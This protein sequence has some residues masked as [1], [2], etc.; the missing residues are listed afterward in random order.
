M[1]EFLKGYIKP[2][3][4]ILA[5]IIAFLLLLEVLSLTYFSKARASDYNN[6]YSETM[7]FYN[8][9]EN[10]LQIIGIGNSD[11]Y[12]GFAPPVIWHEYGYT[13]TAIGAPRQSPSECYDLLREVMDSQS[14]DVVFIECDMLYDNNAQ[15]NYITSK[16]NSLDVMFDYL[17]Q[18][19]VEEG[20][21]NVL[22]IF[23]FHDRWKN[24]K[25]SS[26]VNKNHGYKF[27]DTII[28]VEMSEGYMDET[29]E[30]E[31]IP[32]VHQ[33]S[34]KAII[35]LCR[36]NGAVP[37][38]LTL[39][40]PSSWS[41]KRHTAVQAFADE[42]DV[43]FIDMNLLFDELDLDLKND[44][45]DKGNHLNYYGATKASS[46]LGKYCHDNLKMKDNRNDPDFDYWEKGYKEF[47]AQINE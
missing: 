10:S 36:E 19:S 32:V 41:A 9:P 37:V 46:Y 28:P 35:E 40:S 5:F 26:E 22:P 33:N 29:T 45:R 8:E 34:T 23:T 21:K 27:S 7:S 16:Q 42:N 4:R 24:K 14:P 2:V 30:I 6:K 44:Y 47:A 38:L 20:V 25:I 43:E 13:G 15:E 18:E 31:P 17:K 11:L 1:I 12:S 39:P 3:I